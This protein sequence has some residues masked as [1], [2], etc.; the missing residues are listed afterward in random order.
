MTNY[1]KKVLT[2]DTTIPENSD[3]F[4]SSDFWMTVSSVLNTL[5]NKK[6]FINNFDP[7]KDKNPKPLLTLPFI[8]WFENFNFLQW[9]LI[10]LGSGESTYYF[11]DK[12]KHVVSYETNYDYYKEH[13]EHLKDIE[14]IFKS[15]TQLETFKFDVC[16]ENTMIIIDCA[17]N[18]LSVAKNVI[19]SSPDIIV[20]DNS[21]L[22]P[23]TCS[24]IGKQYLEIPFWGFKK[25]EHWISCT[26]VFIKNTKLNKKLFHKPFNSRSVDL[27]L[28]DR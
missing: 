4:N 9:K 3:L 8:D 7:E 25:S 24:F 23:N 5:Q 2:T 27:N 12:F 21:D 28:W 20:L 26:S 6:F 22:Y 17:C 19:E 14:Y 13:V 18:R 11:T 1:Y 10:E 15:K 16:Q